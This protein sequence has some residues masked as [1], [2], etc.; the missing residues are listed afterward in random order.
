MFA[1]PIS[2]HFSPYIPFAHRIHASGP[3]SIDAL[4]GGQLA[5]AN[6]FHAVPFSQSA[7][8]NGHIDLIEVETLDI[9]EGGTQQHIRFEP[10][11]LVVHVDFVII[12][13]LTRCAIKFRSISGAKAVGACEGAGLIDVANAIENVS[14]L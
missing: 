11:R 5:Q 13:G 4:P 6:P 8:L 9:E 12:N 3:V 10:V 2:L 1:P 14:R 7:L